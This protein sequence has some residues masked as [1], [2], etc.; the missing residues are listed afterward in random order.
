MAF[1]GQS[2]VLL[3]S[4]RT[5]TPC[6]NG[7]VLDALIWSLRESLRIRI[8]ANNSVVVGSY[9]VFL[10]VVYSDILR[11]P[12]NAVVIAAQIMTLSS[13][14]REELKRFLLIILRR[15]GVMGRRL[16]RVWDRLWARFMP[17]SSRYN[18]SKSLNGVPSSCKRHW[19][20]MAHRW[21]F[22]FE[23]KLK[24]AICVAKE[25]EFA[26]LGGREL[27]CVDYRRQGM[28]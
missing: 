18:L 13:N 23:C 14:R 17:R 8:S 21:T 16:G 19:C 5:V 25:S 2:M 26:R 11:K 24:E 20:L 1:T 15:V 10:W 27:G 28:S 22:T 6:L 12:K 7:S 9:C 3:A 4:I